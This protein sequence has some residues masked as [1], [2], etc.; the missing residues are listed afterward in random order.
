MRAAPRPLSR[1]SG[2]LPLERFCRTPQ[3]AGKY[4]SAHT[5]SWKFRWANDLSVDGY[6]HLLRSLDS[7]GSLLETS[8]L[9][10]DTRAKLAYRPAGDFWIKTRHPGLQV[11]GPFR[12]CPAC[13]AFG[14]AIYF[15]QLAALKLC[16]IHIVPLVNACN[17]GAPG[18]AYRDYGDDVIAPY[19]C[20]NCHQSFVGGDFDPEKLFQANIEVHQFEGAF[21]PLRDWFSLLDRD[22][23]SVKIGENPL[24]N[25]ARAERYSW[26]VEAIAELRLP[27]SFLNT[28]RAPRSLFCLETK[29]NAHIASAYQWDRNHPV[30]VA[31][32]GVRRH[33]FNRYLKRK[34]RWRSFYEFQRSNCFAG[35]HHLEC[36]KK[37]HPLVH[38]FWAWRELLSNVGFYFP[39]KPQDVRF[40]HF[41]LGRRA[42]IHRFGYMQELTIK[43]QMQYLLAFFYECVMLTLAQVAKNPEHLYFE[44]KFE[45]DAAERRR[46]A[47][48]MAG[49]D[50][51]LS[52]T[53]AP[54]WDGTALITDPPFSES[55]QSE[56]LE[57]PKIDRRYTFCYVSRS[58][59]DA[60]ID[61]PQ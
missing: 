57:E 13:M 7:E 40:E 21:I 23:R 42:A 17:C 11:P 55:I 36:P 20:N 30:V 35:S 59:A 46:E 24:D 16:P 33:I 45:A 15:F 3:W 28:M 26:T 18:P 49:S 9:S 37:V 56:R 4:E 6:R 43:S 53:L 27:R 31:Y 34:N 47:I 22:S 29:Y 19:L 14:Y 1:Q 54:F 10:P 5:L 61:D 32:L 48:E 44:K 38:A 50:K 8:A 52:L 25:A 58:V 2:P 12:F 39:P 60:I 51:T 41:Q